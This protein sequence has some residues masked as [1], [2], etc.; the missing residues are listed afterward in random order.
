VAENIVTQKVGPLP[1]VVWVAGGAGIIGLFILMTHKGNNGASANQTNQVSSLAP[2]EAEAFGTIE[3][4]QQDVVNA[5]TTLGQNQS[6]LGGSMSTLTGIVTQQG[7]DN[8]SAF[9]N[10]VDGQNSIKQGQTDASTQ[11]DKYYTGLLSNLTNYYNSMSGQLN[12]I[13]SNVTAQGQ[14][15]Y[16]YQQSAYAWLMNA[17]QGISGQVSGVSSQQATA[18][19]Q[20]SAQQQA[21][22]AAQAA[23]FSG[24]NNYLNSIY[25]TE[26][27]MTNWLYMINAR[28]SPGGAGQAQNWPGGQIPSW[29]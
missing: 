12:G 21:Q 1:L 27:N 9:Q 8:A 28:V 4:Q 22:A 7:A 23:G 6:A 13:N 20:L 5:L 26:G 14:A 17:L 18:F 16:A 10:L 3:Q 24:I 19:G 15:N 29:F 2:T 11:A 25:S